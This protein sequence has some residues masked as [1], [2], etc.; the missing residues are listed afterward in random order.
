MAQLILDRLSPKNRGSGTPVIRSNN[1]FLYPW[2]IWILILCFTL[3]TGYSHISRVKVILACKVLSFQ[4]FHSMETFSH[5]EIFNYAGTRMV[6]GHKVTSIKKEKSCNK[7]ISGFFLSGR[8]WLC[9]SGSSL[10]LWELWR[11]GELECLPFSALN[12]K[13]IWFILIK[14]SHFISE[15]LL[16]ETLVVSLFQGITAGCKDIYYNKHKAKP[17][18]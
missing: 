9:W 6:E 15:Y 8:Q 7:I 14:T 4:H 11:S 18:K 12:L 10:W 16:R 1:L 3:H 17:I 5:F 2:F 13:L